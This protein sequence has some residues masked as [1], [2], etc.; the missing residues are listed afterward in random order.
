MSMREKE[1]GR[2]VNPPVEIQQREAMRQKLNGMP[3][4]FMNA[5]DTADLARGIVY[6]ADGKRMKAN[7][8]SDRAELMFYGQPNT[9]R[10][11]AS[12]NKLMYQIRLNLRYVNANPAA[13]LELLEEA[14]GSRN[15]LKG[16][17][18]DQWFSNLKPY[19]KLAYRGLWPG[20]DLIFYEGEHGFKYDVLLHPGADIQQV[21]FEYEGADG[22]FIDQQGG[23]EI[24]TSLQTIR[25]SIPLSYQRVDG[26]QQEI[27]C[28]YRIIDAAAKRF[29]YALMDS[30]N[31]SLPLTIDPM[32]LYSKVIGAMNGYFNYVRSVAIDSEGYAYGSGYTSGSDF[33]V[34]PGAYQTT[35][36]GVYDAFVFKMTPKGD[37][38]VYATYLGGTRDDYNSSIAIDQDGNAYVTGSTYSLDFP[39]TP[40][41]ISNPSTGGVR[42]Y[43]SKLNASGSELIYSAVFGGSGSNGVSDIAVDSEGNAY[44]T[45]DTSSA[46]FPT[47][48]G[49]LRTVIN[50]AGADSYVSKINASG[51]DFLYSTYLGG[52]S[53]NSA[54]GIA[55]NSLGH[56]YVGG[57][58][59]SNN[60]P[61]TAGAFSTTYSGN[62]DGFIAQLNPEGSAL[63]YA[64]Y[65]GGNQSDT[66][67]DIAIDDLGNAYVTGYTTSTNFPTT[68][69][70]FLTTSPASTNSFVTKLNKTGSELVYST[71]LGG[72]SFDA[73]YGIAVDKSHAAY[74]TGA[75]SSTDFPT[76]PGAVQSKRVGSQNVFFTIVSLTGTDLI[77]STYYG[78]S[79][80]DT[81]ESIS[82]NALGQALIG[83]YSSSTNFPS[84]LKNGIRPQKGFILKF[85]T[86]GP[87]G[88]T[89]PTGST[90][91]DGTNGFYRSDRCNGTNGI[92]SAKPASREH[93]G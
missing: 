8:A 19:Y 1:D 32:L 71:Y 12:N 70:A 82:V 43:L 60:F 89:G 54:N 79:S 15:Y 42:I 21:Q 22:L 81:G 2:E 38:L 24:H 16:G 59:A 35:F 17:T 62:Y 57:E 75:T 84:N 77:Y 9:N 61:V 56:A 48:T 4:V 67:S 25:E 90:G 37:N 65:L 53:Y 58:T 86:P 68:S 40:G 46:D 28:C 51:S 78:G 85:G 34:T 31:P 80:S 72:A 30:Y 64:T 29:G 50:A 55:V 87:T 7:F 45:G 39:I 44:L 49:A 41:A 52:S 36:G 5:F 73:G 92:A 91:G 26:K 23:L 20:V 88:P 66:I 13:K 6:S 14:D 33:P 11:T 47:T 18:R 74:I 3:L 83:G 63:L 10:P 93:Y 76:T 69:S 27:S